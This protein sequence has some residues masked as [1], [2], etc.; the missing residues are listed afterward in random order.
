MPKICRVVAFVPTVNNMLQ[1]EFAI[2]VM[3]ETFRC[4]YG[5]IFKIK[6]SNEASA[7]TVKNISRQY[8]DIL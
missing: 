6:F 8:K 5:T 4:K 1:Y 3:M 7:K 2:E